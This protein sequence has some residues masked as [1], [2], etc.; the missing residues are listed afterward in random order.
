MDK[1]SIQQGLLKLSFCAVLSAFLVEI[2]DAGDSLLSW[3]SFPH[4]PACRLRGLLAELLVAFAVAGL[5]GWY[6]CCGHFEKAL[7]ETW[8]ACH[9]WQTPE[10]L[11]FRG[12][13][14][15]VLHADCIECAQVSVL[16]LL[17]LTPLSAPQAKLARG[18]GSPSENPS[19][20]SPKTVL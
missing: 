2:A 13:L 11:C 3:R 7:G 5:C 8:F 15:T 19:E 4:R 10:I 14:C 18:A 16:T 1:P 12:A 20:P 6:G 17:T 9:R